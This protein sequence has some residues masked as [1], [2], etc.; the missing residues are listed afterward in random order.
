MGS[1][2]DFLPTLTQGVAL[3]GLLAGA[4]AAPLAECA[5]TSQ[6]GVLADGRPVYQYTLRNRSGTEAHVISLGATLRALTLRDRR[7]QLVDVVLGYD[8]L[9]EYVAGRGYLGATIGRYANRIANAELPLNGKTYRLV[10]NNGAHTLHGGASGFSSGLWERNGGDG[11]SVRL[12]FVSADG[13]QGFPGELTAWVTYTLTDANEL[14]I[15]YE[16]RTPATTVVNFTNHSYFNLGGAGVGD[17]L[18]QTFAVRANAYTPADSQ[19]IPTGEI[20]SVSGTAFDFREP[21]TLG[22]RLKAV[23]DPNASRQPGFDVN[24]VLTDV[25]QGLR[26]AARLQ[27]PTTGLRLEVLTTE[28]GLQLFTPNFPRGFLTGKGGRDYG[29]AAALCFEPQHFPDSPHFAHFPTTVLEP[30]KVFRSETVYRFS[31]ARTPLSGF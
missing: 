1:R 12:K 9:P 8:T 11:E 3:C 14:K 20:A 27:D 23:R 4:M 18:A 2:T 13:D 24:L 5:T 7:G 31:I 19:G 26:P 16:A 28:P 17:V 25:A 10:A 15:S 29:G 6:F 22:E 30:G 21:K